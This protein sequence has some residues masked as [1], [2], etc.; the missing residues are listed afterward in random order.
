M[1]SAE[2][3]P[4][5]GP[6][7]KRQSALATARETPKPAS[8]LGSRDGASRTRT[9]GLLGAIQALASPEFLLICRV[10]AAVEARPEARVFG[11]F[12][13]ISAG[14]G[15]KKRLFGRISADTLPPPRREC[16]SPVRRK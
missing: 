8:L 15:A 16:R 9:G 12:A 1:R 10:F 13:P 7:T 4:K 6:T 3:G 5:T 14:I 2:I 11:Q